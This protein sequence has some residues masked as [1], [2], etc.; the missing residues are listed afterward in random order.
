MIESIQS[1][2]RYSA[3]HMRVAQ[4]LQRSRRGAARAALA[5]LPEGNQEQASIELVVRRRQ[6]HH[7]EIARRIVADVCHWKIEIPVAIRAEMLKRFDLDR[8]GEQRSETPQ[9]EVY[10]AIDDWAGNRRRAATCRLDAH[11]EQILRHRSE[12]GG[13]QFASPVGT[14]RRVEAA[15]RIDQGHLPCAN[16]PSTDSFRGFGAYPMI[17]LTA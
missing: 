3:L 13:R 11:R 2:G 10:T 6:M 8:N 9:I 15:E 4:T 16:R 17:A 14:M 5:K 1:A 7:G 12:L